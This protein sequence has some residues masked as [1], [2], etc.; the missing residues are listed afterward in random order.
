VPLEIAPERAEALARRLRVL[1]D[2]TRLQM[3]ELLA[4]QET[5]LCVCDVTSAFPLSQPTIS[6][7]LRLLREE[8]LIVA[9]KRG[10]WSYYRATDEG[11]RVLALVQDG[12]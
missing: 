11:A 6:H 10:V 3:L 7:H 1:G 2:A 8:G 12:V 4:R 9:E 5:P